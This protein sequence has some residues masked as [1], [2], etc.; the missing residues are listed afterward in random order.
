MGVPVSG[1]YGVLRDP[2]MPFLAGALDP[3]EVQSRIERYLSHLVRDEGSMHLR[4]IWVIRHKSG[5]RCL[6]EYDI[7]T[8][9]S[10]KTTLVGKARARGTDE[11]T[12]RVQRALWDASAEVGDEAGFSVPEPVGVIPEFHMWLQRKV[13][14]VPATRLLPEAGGIELA[15][16]IAEAAHELHCKGVPSLRPTHTMAD[17]LCI[18][19]ERLPE[20]ARTRPWLKGRLERLLGACDRLG[21]DL[22]RPEPRPI[23]RDF[24]PDQVLVDGSRLYLLDLDLYCEGDPGLDIG[25]FIGH[26]TEQSLRTLDVPDALGEQEEA[27]QERFVELSGEAV[28]PA[29]RTYATLTLARHVHI[30]TL[31]P[32]R[33]PFTESILE[34]CEERLGIAEEPV[35]TAANK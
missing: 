2:R 16:R 8:Q 19:H 23:H 12:Y 15:R 21:E 29:V 7:E 30:S 10:G 6:I 26:L 20:V 11:R 4:K 27:L 31:F 5:R 35:G 28:R 32:D 14:G 34:L 1:P 25:N 24:Y 9:R 18:L 17:E 13:P 3:S 22:P 33:R